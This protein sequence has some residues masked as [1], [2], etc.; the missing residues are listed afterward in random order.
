MGQQQEKILRDAQDAH[1]ATRRELQATREQ[2]DSKT[3]ELGEL[4]QSRTKADTEIRDLKRKIDELETVNNYLHRQLNADQL[5]KVS[6]RIRTDA[7]RGRLDVGAFSPV[8]LPRTSAEAGRSAAGE[9][10]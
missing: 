7:G 8:G 4:E 6:E 2:L 9:T 3:K 1:D 10:F 5:D